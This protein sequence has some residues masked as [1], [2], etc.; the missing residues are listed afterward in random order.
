MGALG[1]KEVFA[2]NLRFY[3][4]DSKQVDVCAKL[5]VK[6]TTMSDWINAKKYPRIDK[7]EMLA[8]YFGIAKSDLIEDKASG[9]KDGDLTYYKPCFKKRVP[10]LGR[11]AAGEPVFAD[12]QAERYDAV[13]DE[14][15]SYGLIV[16]GDSMHPTV[17]ENAT[18]YVA[19]DAETRNGDIVVAL[20]NGHD[21]AL[22]RIYVY[23]DTVALR[24]D[25]EKYPEQVYR[26][27]E[28]RVLGKVREVR[29]R[30]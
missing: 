5:G 11:I 30:F 27:E 14:S 25:N 12:E 20:V 15:I 16:R 22:K 3:L 29:Y 2:R 7:I 23:G 19:R 4:G 18:V 13:E 9:L 26:A 21:A 10:I 6:V 17:R 28:V 8:A 1:N 24:S